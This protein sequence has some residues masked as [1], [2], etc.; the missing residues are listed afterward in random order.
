MPL[1]EVQLQYPV[2]CGRRRFAI[3]MEPKSSF[4]ALGKD[5]KHEG[6]GSISFC[7]FSL[8]KLREQ[9]LALTPP[10]NAFSCSRGSSFRACFP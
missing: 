5:L 1:D 10:P 3:E 4:R 8:A 6:F 2:A 9:P 7:C